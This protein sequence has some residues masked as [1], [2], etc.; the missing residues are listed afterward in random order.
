MSKLWEDL[1]KN[2]KE[3]SNV[4]VEK[5]EEVSKMA[6]A[7]T[8]ELT[9]ISKIKIEI[10]Q[11]QKDLDSTYEKLGYW[12]E[13]HYKS[14]KDLKLFK[15][16]EFKRLL[17]QLDNYRSEIARKEEVINKIREEVETYES[18]EEASSGSPEKEEEKSS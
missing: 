4:A 8:E 10:H 16:D 2:M 15:D 6:V 12:I 3:W 1:K 17:D 11:H 14:N 18:K 9:K 5:A 7:K 13:S